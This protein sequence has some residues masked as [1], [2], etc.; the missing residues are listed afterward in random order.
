MIEIRNLNK[1]YD[2]VVLDI[3]ELKIHKSESIGL[4]GNNGAGKTTLLRLILDLIKATKGN[5]HSCEIN[6]AQ[7]DHWKKYTGAFLDDNF[8]ISFLKPQ[9]YLEFVGKLH[10]LSKD[11]IQNFLNENKLFFSEDI[12]DNKRFIR[13]LSKGNKSK[14]GILGAMINNPDLIILDEPFANIDPSS[15][16]WLMAK[17]KALNEQGITIIVSSHNLNQLSDISSR[18]LLLEK[19]L[20]ITDTENTTSTLSELENYFKVQVS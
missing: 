15:Q 7:S 20:L 4:V 1:T 12:F 9:E 11:D 17:L 8:L 14:V 19:G 6:V 13:D 10:G 2:K 3:G 5:V 16:Q 18:I